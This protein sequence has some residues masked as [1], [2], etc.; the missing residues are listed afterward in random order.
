MHY[1]RRDV[2]TDRDY[3]EDD[4]GGGG[5]P[6]PPGAGR[7]RGRGNMPGMHAGPGGPMAPGAPYGMRP[8]M[9]QMGGEPL[10]TCSWSLLH[11]DTHK[12]ALLALRC[13]CSSCGLC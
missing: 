3:A 13:A 10:L 4:E 2:P 5:R 11:S 12:D 9:M 6:R 8:G 7:G 1:S